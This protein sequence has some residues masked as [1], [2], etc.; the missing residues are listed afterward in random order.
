MRR[1]L[2]ILPVFL[3]FL[4]LLVSAQQVTYSEYDREDSKDINFEIIGKISNNILVYKNIRWKHKLS[5]YDNE[6]NTI[7][8]IRLDFIPEKTF[9]VDF[10]AY[11]DFFYIIYQYQKQNI[12][13]CMGIKMDANGNKMSEPV[14]MDTTQIAMLANN[15]IYTAITSED[16]KK[17][18]VYKIQKKFERFNIVTLLFDEQLHLI[19]KSGQTM[20]FDER[21]EKYGDFMLDNEGNLVFT[22]DKQEGYRENS[23]Q[24]QL[25]TKRPLQDTFAFHDINLDK[26][27]I[28][29]VSI[30]IDNLNKRYIISSFYYPK[31]RGSIEGLFTCTWDKVNE[32]QDPSAFNYFDNTI[33]V[34]ESK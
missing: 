13:H 4:P 15:K 34:I 31:S 24:L 11:P 23:N 29:E 21:R 28:D 16:K 18:M 25:V 7:E 32:K 5:I 8:T 27:Y 2:F 30:K 19:N 17:I 20:S 9:N 1:Q 14:E 12:L 10:V 6:M 22:L 3:F 33:S 26:K